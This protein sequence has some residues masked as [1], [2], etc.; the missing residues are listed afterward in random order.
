MLYVVILNKTNKD[1]ICYN[2]LQILNLVHFSFDLTPPYT[3]F[4][5]YYITLP[6]RAALGFLVSE[7]KTAFN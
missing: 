4:T 5:I 1:L 3:L 7:I 2:S 6:Y